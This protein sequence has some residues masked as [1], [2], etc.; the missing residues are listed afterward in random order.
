MTE[1]LELTEFKGTARKCGQEYGRRFEQ[2]IMGFCRQEVGPDRTRSKY[3]ERCW[4]YVKRDAPTSAEFLEGMAVGSRLSLS[5]L[6]LLTLHEEI[7][8]LPHC[9]A[10]LATGS[11][12]RGRK[13]INAQ[14]WDWAPSLFGWPGLLKLKIKGAC[15]TLTY[16]YPGLWASA[17][18]NLSGLTFMW[19]GGGYYPQLRPRVGIPTYVLIAEILRHKTVDEVIGYLKSIKHAGSFLFFLTDAQGAAAVVE[20][21]PG[22]LAIEPTDRYIT[23]ANHYVCPDI[24]RCSRQKLPRSRKYTTAQRAGRMEELVRQS[25]GSITVTTAKKV[26]TDRHGKWPWLHQYPSGGDHQIS[27]RSMTIDSLIAVSQDRVLHTCR[28]GRIP[29]PWQSVGL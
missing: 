20:G 17:G 26:L 18:I 22:R 16:H 15:E 13:S 10:F 24:V 4:K 19:T 9:T 8:H 7:A 3:A 6:V 29:S 1:K 11:A 25:E 12:T 27:L 5:H 2:Q 21:T 28:G 14:N 23:R